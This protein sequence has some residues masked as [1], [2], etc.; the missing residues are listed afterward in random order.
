MRTP[1]EPLFPGRALRLFR[2]TGVLA[3]SAGLAA[4]GGPAGCSLDT[5]PDG[6]ADAAVASPDASPPADASAPQVTLTYLGD[7]QPILRARCGMC[8]G[9]AAPMP[10]LY[11]QFAESYA[12]TQLPSKRCPGDSVGTC[13]GLAVENQQP[14]GTA[15]RTYV[16]RP[17]HREGWSCL[18]ESEREKIAA[19][20]AG[21]MLER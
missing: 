13:V 15:C 18:T 9:A 5:S 10:S 19:W 11:V 4:L 8:H 21:G 6:G 14:E 12:E 7:V 3:L 2:S 1:L 20:V 17:F 16:V